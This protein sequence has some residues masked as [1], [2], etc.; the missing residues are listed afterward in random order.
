V[1]SKLPSS[2]KISECVDAC[3]SSWK[4]DWVNTIAVQQLPDLCPMLFALTKSVEVGGGK[5]W[6]PAFVNATGLAEDS[7]AEPVRLAT[8]VYNE[9]LLLRALEVKD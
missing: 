5:E 4:K 6:V 3:D 9:L 8:Q 7:K 2:V 1:K